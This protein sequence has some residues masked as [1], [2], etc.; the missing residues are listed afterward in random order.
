MDNINTESVE[1]EDN[2]TEGNIMYKSEDDT[3]DDE[4]E[5]ADQDLQYIMKKPTTYCF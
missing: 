1:N 2:N 5:K 3:I 4:T